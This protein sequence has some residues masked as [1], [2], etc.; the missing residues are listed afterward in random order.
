MLRSLVLLLILS[1]STG[2]AADTSSYLEQANAILDKW[3]GRKD[4]QTSLISGQN[5][6]WSIRTTGAQLYP[7]MVLTAWFTNPGL[8]DGLLLET[9]RDEERLTSRISVFPDDYALQNGRVSRSSRNPIE[10]QINAAVYAGGLARISSVVGPGPWSDRLAG[11]V[12]ALFL[13]A[14]VST[15]YADGPLPSNDIRVLGHTLKTLP[16]LAEQSGDEGYLYY[17]RR[18]GDA[19]CVGVMPK[20]GGLP[21]ERWD[22]EAD[23][24]K[25]ASLILNEDGVAFIEG[26]VSLYQAEVLE[27]TARADIYRP[28]LSSMFDVLLERGLKENGRFYRRIQPDGRGGYSIDRKRESLLTLR[29]LIAA[30]QYGR[31]SGNAAYADRAIRELAR[32]GLDEERIFEDVPAI[33]TA[34][35]FTDRVSE[36]AS[37]AKSLIQSAPSGGEDEVSDAALLNALLAAS[38]AE[39]AGARLLPWQP[40]LHLQAKAQSSTLTVTVSSEQPWSG[41]MLPN[42]NRP[43]PEIVGFPNL[44]TSRP[45]DAYSVSL[46]G[47]SGYGIIP[48][49]MLAK[50]LRL[51]VEK[52][53]RFTIAPGSPVERPASATGKN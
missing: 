31:L 38:W 46:I 4:T 49:S 3:S 26:L 23:R 48:G 9:L 43:R 18:I 8:F 33:M 16:L 7:A 6:T 2:T 29:I 44:Y 28:P 37:T 15:G 35:T 40:G 11:I 21:A 14:D 34:L 19:Y 52:D 53:L 5:N 25:A 30:Y 42:S 36:L 10:I 45:E 47:A 24:A 50:G 22:F 51:T 27:S 20:N 13:R 1:V 12:D 32:Y 17:A 41:R 39:S